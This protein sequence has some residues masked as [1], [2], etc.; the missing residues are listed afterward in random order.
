MLFVFH[1]RNSANF[2][3]ILIYLKHRTLVAPPSTNYDRSAGSKLV[4]GPQ[5][6]VRLGQLVDFLI[7]VRP[8]LDEQA[9]HLHADLLAC[10]NTLWRLVHTARG[11][12]ESGVRTSED[13]FD[14]LQIDLIDCAFGYV[15]QLA[16]YSNLTLA[17]EA[18]RF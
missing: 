6:Q 12:Q 5:H 2:H 3:C 9:R 10:A 11:P 17:D 7:T 14:Q 8:G 18:V 15:A 13:V 1:T 16:V 4:D